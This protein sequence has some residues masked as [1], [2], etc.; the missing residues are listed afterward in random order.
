MA[1]RTLGGMS[2]VR[3]SR[4][5]VGVA[6]CAVAC[7][8]APSSP[9]PPAPP[10]VVLA[11]IA[12]SAPVA[13]DAG[14]TRARAPSRCRAPAPGEVSDDDTPRV[15]GTKGDVVMLEWLEARGVGNESALSFLASRYGLGADHAEAVFAYDRCG[16]LTVGDRAEEAILCTPAIPWTIVQTHA[17][18]LVV[19]NKRPAVVLDVGL[20]MVA[21][22][23]PDAH[24]LDLGVSAAP[25]GR[26]IELRDRAPN[27]T[28][29][30]R[31]LSECRAREAELDTCEDLLVSEAPD[32]KTLFVTT[33][34]GSSMMTTSFH[35]CPLM[36]GRDGKVQVVRDTPQSPLGDGPIEL[37]DCAGGRP[38]MLE[39]QRSLG[40]SSPEMRNDARRALAFFDKTCAQR[41][42]WTWKGER[43]VKGP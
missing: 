36:L 10:P 1:A 16:T 27:G 30:V 9:P 19:R 26:T 4:I 18:V 37:R 22:D 13:V 14:A 41:G 7:A 38:P 8:S 43:F 3:E 11:P 32:P 23:F 29:L 34:S 24:W 35:D 15:R 28:K 5:F 17:V 39:M 20:G 2:L 33:P 12:T 25:D 42:T 40:T 21:L 31:A 6:S